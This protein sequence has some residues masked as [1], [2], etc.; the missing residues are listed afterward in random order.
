MESDHAKA[1]RLSWFRPTSLSMSP[2]H[3]RV[4]RG[5]TAPARF[6]ITAS[7]LPHHPSLV[8]AQAASSARAALS[9]AADGAV[10]PLVT[11]A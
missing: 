2:R 10:A 3:H 1:V 6:G 9:R 5:T 7:P 8:A 4:A 11:R